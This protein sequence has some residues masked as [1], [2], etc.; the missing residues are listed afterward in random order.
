[1]NFNLTI[2][3]HPSR[4]STFELAPI[5]SK[6]SVIRVCTYGRPLSHPKTEPNDTKP[7]CVVKPSASVTVIGP[8]LSPL[9]GDW[10]FSVDVQMWLSRMESGKLMR[11]LTAEITWDLLK[12]RT[13]EI[14]LLPALVV[15]QP[16]AVAS[17]LTKLN[18]IWRRLGKRAYLMKSV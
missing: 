8:P 3:Y 18:G 16:A 4:I 12:L 5:K 14:T 15:P 7:I 17:W 13:G 1:M 11:Q 9:H 2:F 6:Y 10:P